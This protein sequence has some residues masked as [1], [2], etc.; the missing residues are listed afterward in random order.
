MAGFEPGVVRAPLHVFTA[1]ASLQGGEA[2][3][4]AWFAH[5]GNPG[6]SSAQVLAGRHESL[7]QIDANLARIARVLGGAPD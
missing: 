2:D 6:Q 4:V 5:T 1:E 7:M 3:P